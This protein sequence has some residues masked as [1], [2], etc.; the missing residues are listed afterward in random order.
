MDTGVEK[1]PKRHRQMFARMTQN[2]AAKCLK[3]RLEVQL[4]ATGILPYNNAKT[5]KGENNNFIIRV[6]NRFK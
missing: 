6:L 1:D 3:F 5:G 4:E 2:I